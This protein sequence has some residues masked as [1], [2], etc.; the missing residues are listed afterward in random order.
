M[1]P[2]RVHTKLL[3]KIS[4][5]FY[6]SLD[7][8]VGT[9]ECPPALSYGPVQGWVT[10]RCSQGDKERVPHASSPHLEKVNPAGKRWG[11]STSPG[12]VN[13]ETKCF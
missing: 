7:K 8:A 5:G 1:T 6:Q 2:F 3:I 9:G 11:K 10:L 4:R 12:H 13:R